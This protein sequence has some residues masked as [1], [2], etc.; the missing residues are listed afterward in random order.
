MSIR[1]L[2]LPGHLQWIFLRRQRVISSKYDGAGAWQPLLP[3]A[4]EQQSR[5]HRRKCGRYTRYLRNFDGA[6]RVVWSS[7][8]MFLTS[9]TCHFFVKRWCESV[10][11]AVAVSHGA[12]RHRLRFAISRKIRNF[13]RSFRRLSC[14]AASR[15]S[16]FALYQHPPSDGPEEEPVIDTCSPRR[17]AI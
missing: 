17:Q 15:I 7:P 3:S 1:P 13:A 11:T 8:A 2:G 4:A 10:I 5:S 6:F 12:C 14:V 16:H 9:A